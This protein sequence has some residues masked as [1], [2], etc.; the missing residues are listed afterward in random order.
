MEFA[1]YMD[2]TFGPRWSPNIWLVPRPPCIG[3][4]PGHVMCELRQ[5]KGRA[6]SPEDFQLCCCPHALVLSCSCPFAAHVKWE[7]GGTEM[8][9][10]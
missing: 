2:A 3:Y 6:Q 1:D 7:R 8:P 10:A 4:F 5:P 9:P